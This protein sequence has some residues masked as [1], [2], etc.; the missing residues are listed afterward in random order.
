MTTEKLAKLIIERVRDES[1]EQWLGNIDGKMKGATA[2]KVRAL[3]KDWPPRERAVLNRLIPAIVDTV[4]HNL[5]WTI[6]Q[7]P[8]IRLSY[9][10]GPQLRDVGDGLPGDLV[11]WREKYSQQPVFDPFDV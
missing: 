7:D 2:K 9:G 10:N 3:I 1:I 5:M 6:E 4:L 11:S 8:G